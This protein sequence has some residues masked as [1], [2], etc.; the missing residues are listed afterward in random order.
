G[1]AAHPQQADQG[2]QGDQAEQPPDHRPGTQGGKSVKS[3]RIATTP[4][5]TSAAQ[6]IDATGSARRSLR[7]SVIRPSGSG[8]SGSLCSASYSQSGRKPSL[9]RAGQ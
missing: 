6:P 2:G 7:E 5:T 9:R 8:I 4:T 3:A 1:T